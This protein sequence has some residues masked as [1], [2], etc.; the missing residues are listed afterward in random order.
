MPAVIG[1]AA[2][3]PQKHGTGG[4]IA[5]NERRAPVSGTQRKTGPLRMNDRDCLLNR[6]H[7]QQ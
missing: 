1:Q 5:D 2:E 4:E 7:R 3:G 6:S